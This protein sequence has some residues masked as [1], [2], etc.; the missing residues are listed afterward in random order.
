MRVAA[1]GGAIFNNEGI[2]TVTGST[3]TNNSANGGGAIGIYY[4]VSPKLQSGATPLEII[5]DTFFNNSTP[6]GPGGAVEIG[7][8]SGN[9]T[10]VT[11]S[12]FV[13]NSAQCTECGWAIDALSPLILANDILEGN[14][15]NDLAVSGGEKTFPPR[16]ADPANCKD[17]ELCNAGGNLVGYY[18]YDGQY[19]PFFIAVEPVAMQLTPLGGYGGPTP[20]MIPLPGSPA[21]CAGTATPG[22]YLTLTATDQRGDPRTNTSY[23]GYSSSSPCVDAGAV[24]T[25]YSMA[26]STDPEP[27]SGA[28]EIDAETPFEAA[29]TLDESGVPFG[30]TVTPPA[31]APSVTI[32]LELTGGGTLT[33]GSAGTAA[34]G[35]AS[36]SL[37]RVSEAGS[38]DTLTANL[39][40]NTRVKPVPMLSAES[41]SFSVEQ[42]TP[43]LAALTSPAAGST[44]SGTSATTFT[45]TAGTA[46]SAYW[47][48][49]GTTGP[50]SSDLYAS[51]RLTGFSTTAGPFPSNGGTIYATLYSVI[52]GLW[53]PANYT[54][55]ESGT[56]VP[57]VLTSPTSGD[58]L[59]S[60]TATTFTWT[61]GI[62]VSAYWLR[63]G[64]AGPGSSDLYASGRMTGISTTAGPFP[65]YGRTIYATLYSV[66]KGVWQP[67]YSTF[68][69]QATPVPAVLTSPTSGS[70]LSSTS[71]TTFT[72]TAGTGVG[73]N[74]LTLGTTG[75]GSSNLYASGR[76]TGFSTTAG[77]FPANGGMIYATL[78]SVINGVWEAENSTF[79]ESGTAAPAT[80]A[81]PAS[82]STLSSTASTTFTWTTGTGVSA[83]WLRL[84]T[85]GPGSSDLYESGRTLTLTDTV[86]PL[87]G[88]GK[89]IYATL[90][91]VIDGVWRATSSTYTES[92]P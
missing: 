52:N 18:S 74:W 40:M 43:V 46:V 82:G 91:S 60:T 69:E 39:T 55:V 34:D 73:A 45:W 42:A 9:P 41:A 76:M 28:S 19:E 5:R 86:G 37:L 90:Y 2:V 33:G 49:L 3:F 23:S 61:T 29:V 8:D 10:V 72:W 66:I 24:Q 6:G 59:S 80:M 11:D 83:Y 35:V 58:T 70:R 79:V 78:Y 4:D 14:G 65:S 30:S 87:P 1:V 71:A 7:V 92:G 64:T 54:F 81:S 13:N 89:K 32:P 44:L 47:L 25:N 68:I 56:P 63:L 62:Q 50:G 26:F 16:Y 51:P 27:L 84:G 17:V 22:G 31:D 36:Y 38:D 48:K 85:T 57:A 67:V 21:I 20:T 12:T 77:P 88:N 15:E 53:Q 75:P